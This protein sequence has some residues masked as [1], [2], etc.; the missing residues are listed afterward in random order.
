MLGRKLCLGS[1]GLTTGPTNAGTPLGPAAARK[2]VV[3]RL[4]F[5]LLTYLA[6]FF[7]L[8]LIFSAFLTPRSK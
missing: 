8:F 1:D 3:N 4:F 6:F 7:L 2:G 5:A